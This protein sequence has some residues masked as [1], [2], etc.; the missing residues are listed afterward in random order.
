MIEGRRYNVGGHHL[1][2]KISSTNTVVSIYLVTTNLLKSFGIGE[3]YKVEGGHI[4]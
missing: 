2:I 3:D 1:H 4:R